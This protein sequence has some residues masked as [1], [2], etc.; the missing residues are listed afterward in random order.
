MRGHTIV[1]GDDA[2]ATR[3]VEE[4][5]SAGASV[6]MLTSAAELAEAGIA[7]AT[8]V[9][10]V[11]HDDAT[12][13]EIA[14]LA[15][16]ANPNV[17]VVAR[18]VN[19]VLRDAVA[20]GNGPGAIL[21]VADLAASSVVEACLSRTTHAITIAGVEVVVSGTEAPRD[22][23][24]RE[25]FGDLAPV[26][27]IRGE[28]SSSPGEVVACPGRDLTVQ[29]GDWTAMLGTADELAAQGIRAKPHT[30]RQQYPA[31]ADGPD[32]RRAAHDPRGRQPGVLPPVGR[33]AGPARR[34]DGDPAGR[35]P[36]TP[37]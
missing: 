15:R 16:E 3:I 30:A 34:L 26:A 18:L 31:H 22:A 13:L 33:H 5:N 37:E 23:T 28:S 11:A 8:A 29:A 7:H 27:V 32:A 19:T 12:N 35:L 9:V 10:C 6:V 4:L 2:L 17:R 25:L 1:C 21:D 24:L 20:A 36:S 14:L